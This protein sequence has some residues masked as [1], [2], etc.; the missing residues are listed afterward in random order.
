[1]EARVPISDLNAHLQAYQAQPLREYSNAKR[2]V[3][4]VSH[5]NQY[6]IVRRVGNQAELE[7]TPDCPCS[8]DD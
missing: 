4:F 2:H 3:Y 8:Y 1:M 7:F 5:L 6:I